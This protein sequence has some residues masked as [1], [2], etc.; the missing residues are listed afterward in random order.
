MRKLTVSIVAAVAVVIAGVGTA[1]IALSS[2]VAPAKATEPVTR[3]FAYGSQPLQKLDAYL[4]ADL[5]DAPPG[6]AAMPVV[7]LVHGGGWTRGDK[8]SMASAAHTALRAG[9]VAVSVNY[10]LAPEVTPWPTQRKDLRR[11]LGWVQENAATLQGDPARVF[12]LGSSAGG[13]IGLGTLTRGSGTELARGVVALSPPADLA[14]VASATTGDRDSRVLAKTVATNLPSCIT[15]LPA[16]PLPAVPL[17]AAP[18]TGTPAAP[19]APTS[20][21]TPAPVVGEAATATCEALYAQRSAASQLDA[22]DPAVLLLVSR[23]EWVDPQSSYR[24][25]NAADRIGVDSTLLRF[26]GNRHGMSY[27]NDAW[28]Q[29]RAWIQARS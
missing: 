29:I 5:A 20:T 6:T 2:S 15:A 7:V 28:P 18:P 11:A 9:F 8:A 1:V 3:E 24:L 23:T 26:E 19:T 17:P 4:P 10:R 12:V 14:L 27:F 21:A 22:Q 25:H 16:L 13:E